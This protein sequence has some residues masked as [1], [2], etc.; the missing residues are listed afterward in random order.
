MQQRVHQ[1]SELK[2]PSK[3]C[4]DKER[5]TIEKIMVASLDV[6]YNV[7]A[8][9]GSMNTNGTSERESA[10]VVSLSTSMPIE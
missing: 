9:D 1:I 4:V 5:P 6:S 8:F 7:C 3:Y 2:L 10:T